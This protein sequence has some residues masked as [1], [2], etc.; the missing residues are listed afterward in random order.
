MSHPSAMVAMFMFDPVLRGTEVKIKVVIWFSP[1]SAL[2]KN[3]A[4]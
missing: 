1:S 4:G 3:K 2:W